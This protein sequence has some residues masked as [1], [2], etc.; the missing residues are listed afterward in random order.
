MM[1]GDGGIP[2]IETRRIWKVRTLS[3]RVL[4][5]I[6]KWQALNYP[7]Q[8][9]CADLISK[10][11][12]RLPEPARSCLINIIHDELLFEV[13]ADQA[14][15]VR[16]QVIEAM[17]AAGDAMLGTYGLPIEIEATIGESWCHG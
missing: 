7:I 5:A 6:S 11:M 13:P 4:S 12:A 2:V 10:A 9:S 17:T 16:L 8:A 1:I 15:M 14:E 3:G